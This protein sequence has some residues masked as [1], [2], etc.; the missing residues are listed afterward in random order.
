M[1]NEKNK[2]S[3]QK[4]TALA[5]A[6]RGAYGRNA[7]AIAGTTCSSIKELATQL[8]RKL[9]TQ[10]RL[11]YID[12]R[13]PDKSRS[14][15][16]ENPIIS[17]GID[18]V[19]MQTES[20]QQLCFANG[21]DSYRAKSLFN[22]H[23]LILLNGNHFEAQDQITVIDSRKPVKPDNLSNTKIIVLQQ[24]AT[25][26]PD[27]VKRN[28]KDIDQIPVFNIGETEKIANSINQLLSA[29]TPPLTGLVLAGGKSTRMHTDKT[30]LDYHGK[31]Q[32]LHLYELLNRYC[33]RVFLSCRRDQKKGIPEQYNTITDSFLDMGPLGALLSAFREHPDSALL[34]VACDL[35]LLSP[36]TLQTLVDNRNSSKIA[37]AF[38]NNDCG[39]PEPLITI[40]EPKS[41]QVLLTFL[42]MGYSCPRKTLIN[43]N[44]QLLDPPDP[45]ELMNANNRREYEQAL[46]KLATH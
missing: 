23:D 12:A 8:S 20:V 33:N 42:G 18:L 4:H 13:H 24:E 19:H 38:K 31:P 34:A 41:Y 27:Y 37:T 44:I 35:P 7:L 39:F 46:L 5:K 1:T 15:T 3:H 28:I 21:L 6:D 40:W 11:A 9:S 26:I 43:S 32:R 36:K 2:K 17:A 14:A 30:Q 25:Q 10:Y 29:A 22:E 16:Q 45:Q